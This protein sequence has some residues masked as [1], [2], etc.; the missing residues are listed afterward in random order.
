[1]AAQTPDIPASACNLKHT[2][3]DFDTKLSPIL[4]DKDILHFRRFAKYVAAFWEWPALLPAPPAAISYGLFQQTFPA[5]VRKKNV[6]SSACCARH[7]AVIH[8]GWVLGQQRQHRYVLQALGL[9]CDI[10]TC[11]AYGTF[12]WL[13]LV[14]LWVTSDWEF[15]HLF[16]CPLLVGKINNASILLAFW[17]QNDEAAKSRSFNR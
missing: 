9:R 3:H 4:F 1:M 13:M 15:T 12:W 2:T 14:L 7:K 11:V 8:T 6:H 5:H 10:Q 17:N 16:T